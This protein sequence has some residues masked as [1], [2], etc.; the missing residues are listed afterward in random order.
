MRL[1]IPTCTLNFNNILSSESIS[2]MGFYSRRGF[3]NKR[4]YPVC[5]NDKED[6]ILLYSKYPRFKIEDTGLENYPMVIEIST[7]DYQNGY[8]EQVNEYEG[9]EVYVCYQ[10]INL[11]PFHCRIYF[12][13][14]A[15]LQGVLTKAEQS[16]ENKLYKLYSANLVVK[17]FKKKSI[18]GSFIRSLAQSEIEEFT[19][20]D[21]FPEIEIKQETC[22]N[23]QD[24]IYDRTKGFIYCYLIG[25]NQ[26]VSS[27]IGQ[28]KSIARKLRNTLSAVINSPDKR[29]TQMQDDEISNGI[30]KFNDIYAAIDEDSL[31]NK[32]LLDDKLTNNS[33]GLPSSDVESLLRQMGVFDAFINNLHLRETYDARE[34]RG[35]L[36]YSSSDSLNR[37]TEKMA[38]VVRRLEIKDIAQRERHTVES[39]MNINE[40]KTIKI[41]DNSYNHKF[42]EKLINSQIQGEYKKI[43]DEKGLEE[44]LALAYNGGQILK[45]ML[46][47]KWASSPASSYIKALLNHFQEN[48]SFDLFASDSDVLISFAAFCQKGDNIDRLVEYLIQAGFCNYKLAY[49]IYGATRGF[50]SLPKTFTSTLIDGDKDY[51]QSTAHRVWYLLNGVDMEDATLPTAVERPD[52]PIEVESADIPNQERCVT[53]RETS[54]SFCT[55]FME[56]LK[57]SF[58]KKSKIYREFNNKDFGGKAIVEESEFK[59]AVY[60]I[61]MPII[62]DYKRDKAKIKDRLNETVSYALGMSNVPIQRDLFTSSVRS[63]LIIE[64]TSWIDETADVIT[65]SKVKDKYIED[66][67]WFQNEYKKGDQSQYYAKAS[68]DNRVVIESFKRYLGRRKYAHEI[69]VE[70][71]VDFLRKKYDR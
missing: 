65:D 20:D 8:F 19:W 26:S 54:T 69:D 50:A 47:D 25:A 42:Y 53:E 56:K 51:Y 17:P 64:E 33:L 32:K 40:D 70:R 12:N 23:I 11:N 5:A 48:T 68:R 71:I 29:L 1:Y 38:N 16:L 41:V 28:L 15:E 62:E 31:C 45:A 59:K 24:A 49:G 44:S 37:V 60:N 57:E 35:C 7:D 3:G 66:V 43:M 18:L 30:N 46:E 52:V 39:L 6:A 13:D 10:T 36:E 21:S 58:G 9:I 67:Q 14:C 34:L 4:F 63:G 27:E 55:R 2:P 61:A 22:S